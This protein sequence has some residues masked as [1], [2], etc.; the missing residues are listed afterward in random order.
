MT[1]LNNF[2]TVL[3][4]NNMHRLSFPSAA[5]ARAIEEALKNNFSRWAEESILV[6]D[7]S[8]N[9]KTIS[10]D[11]VDFSEQDL[12]FSSE[13][14]VIGVLQDGSCNWA[15]F[16]FGSQLALCPRDKFFPIILER[17]KQSFFSEVLLLKSLPLKFDNK[18]K[19][20]SRVNTFFC[21]EVMGAAFGV[22]KLIIHQSHLASLTDRPKRSFVT[23]KLASR[24]SS[25]ASLKVT[26]LIK[27]DFGSIPFDELVRINSTHLL[28]SSNSI[29]NQFVMSVGD[30]DICNVAIGKRAD[31]KAFL[32]LKEQ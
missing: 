12:C 24:L 4:R 27:Y 29:K 20:L 6:S 16:V 11:N 23:A 8:I 28:A 2:I 17:A 26:A 9:V 14:I 25:I 32:I 13:S 5:D 15:E 18:R 22:L 3:E 30:V 21:I 19:L 10:I 7:Y 31:K 1:C